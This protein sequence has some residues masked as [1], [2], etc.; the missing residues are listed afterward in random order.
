MDKL[1]GLSFA[2]MMAG[3]GVFC[4][5]IISWAAFVQGGEGGSLL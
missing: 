3:L 4:L 2:L 5:S 1:L